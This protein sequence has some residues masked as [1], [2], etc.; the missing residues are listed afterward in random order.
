[1]LSGLTAIVRVLQLQPVSLTSWGRLPTTTLKFL[2]TTNLMGYFP[3]R[4][5]LCSDLSLKRT[6]STSTCR[7]ANTTWAQD[8][9]HRSNR[10]QHIYNI[11]QKQHMTSTLPGEAYNTGPSNGSCPTLHA[12]PGGLCSAANSNGT[13]G[14]VQLWYKQRLQTPLKGAADHAKHVAFT[15]AIVVWRWHSSNRGHGRHRGAI[16]NEII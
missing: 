15:L 9:R 2:D 1:M 14:C 3:S 16:F 6:G 11:L 12:A 10:A 8:L 13:P 4:P 7:T 5:H